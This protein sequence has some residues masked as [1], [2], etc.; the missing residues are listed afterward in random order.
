MD[1]ELR[2]AEPVWN[3]VRAYHLRPGKEI[4]ALSYLWARVEVKAGVIRVLVPHTA[5]LL[6]FAPDCFERQTSGNVRLHADVQRGMLISFAAS[7]LNA[8][9]NIHDHWFDARTAFSGIDDADDCAFDHYLRD[10]YEPML[11]R[12][13][14]AIPR[15][16]W[17][18]AIVLGREGA[19]ARLIDTRGP[20]SPFWPVRRITV[21]GEH[22]QRIPLRHETLAPATAEA[23]LCRHKDFI[24]ETAQTTL[25]GLHALLVG[26]GGIGSILG[27]ALGRIGVCALTLVDDDTLDETNLNRWQGGKPEMIGRPKATLLARRLRQMFPEMRVRA[28]RRSI[29][30]R[31]VEPYFRTADVIF[32]AVDADAPRYFLNRV[33]L[34]HLLPYFDAGVGVTEGGGEVDFCTRSFTMLPGSTA[35]LECTQF[36]LYDRAKT[37]EAFLD[38]ATAAEWRRAGYV[39]N[40]PEIAAPSVYA[41]NQR[42]VGLTVTE[43]LNWVCGWRP[44]ATLVAESWARGTIQRADRE[45]FPETPDPECPAC[46][47]YAGAGSSEALPRP[48]AFRTSASRRNP[49]VLNR[50]ME[51]ENGPKETRARR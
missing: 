27:E 6:R 14:G 45:N 7:H 19:D 31:A 4:E 9:I 42:V 49:P 29:F 22:Y 12:L 44:T 26:C 39:G 34:Q 25:S 30:D 37:T 2:I 32:G 43:F 15:P 10:T 41:L 24:A 47:Y 18:V 51:N 16:I 40:Q 5:P 23:R 8:L 46:G 36:Q 50:R 28:V 3:A 21:I 11:R 1:A 17:N 48:A 20:G 35:C 13:D 38:P 33:A